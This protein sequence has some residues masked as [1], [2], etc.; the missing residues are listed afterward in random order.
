[1][2]PKL[3]EVIDLGPEI[4]REA[5]DAQMELI[6]T[7]KYDSQNGYVLGS[8]AKGFDQETAEDLAAVIGR[9]PE[10]Q[11]RL[12]NAH[13]ALGFGVAASVMKE[14]EDEFREVA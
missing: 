6:R 14:F 10:L 12:P 1:M 4:M 11:H 3:P 9:N 13:F 8:M 5:S 7:G 2:V